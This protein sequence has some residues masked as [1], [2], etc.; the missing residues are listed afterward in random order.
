VAP[1]LALGGSSAGRPW[2]TQGRHDVVRPRQEGGARLV[3][4]GRGARVGAIRDGEPGDQGLAWRACFGGART[5]LG[6]HGGPGTPELESLGP[7]VERLTEGWTPGVIAAKRWAALAEGGPPCATRMGGLALAI[8]REQRAL[9]EADLPAAVDHDGQGRVE[10]SGP[11]PTAAVAPSVLARESGL[12]AREV[13]RALA[14][15]RLA[16]VV[17]EAGILAGAGDLGGA[18]KDDGPGGVRAGAAFGGLRGR[19][20]GAGEAPGERGAD[21]PTAAAF[22]LTLGGQ[23][24]RPRPVGG[25]RQPARGCLGQGGGGGRGG[26]LV[27]GRGGGHARL[28]SKRRERRRGQGE[29]MAAHRG[30]SLPPDQ[31]GG[32]HSSDAACG[33]I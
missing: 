6:D 13:A 17:T 20:P 16:S 32:W 21:E 30:A 24:D 1:P 26:A 12:K 33:L 2:E 23:R 15:V 8:R 11:D 4:V 19:A 10:S 28:Q 31:M 25:V 3:A 9:D 29:P 5:D 18:C 27:Q 14:V 22:A 7:A